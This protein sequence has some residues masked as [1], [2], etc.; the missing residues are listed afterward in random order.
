[1]D[2]FAESFA[3]ESEFV[4]KDVRVENVEIIKADLVNSGFTWL[5]HQLTR[6]CKDE[7]PQWIWIRCQKPL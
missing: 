7:H 5:D 1:V 2:Y 6:T 3:S 4:N